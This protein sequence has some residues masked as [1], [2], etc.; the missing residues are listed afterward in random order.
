M[1]AHAR[2]PRD[3]FEGRDH[4]EIPAFQRPYV[5][6]E[7]DQW[8][9]L[10]DDVVR[11]AD[12]YVTG[13]LI[14]A[15]PKVPH[16]FLGAVVYESKPLITGDVARHEVIDG[17]QR[18]TTLQVLIDATH[19][20]LDEHGFDDLADTLDEL[21]RNRQNAFK[22]K[23]E[24]F[25]LWPS[26]TDRDA[27]VAVMEGSTGASDHPLRKAH[28]FFLGEVRRWVAG[29]PDE[30]DLVPPGTMELRVEALASTL[31]D[32]LLLVAID[33][34]GHD[35][36]Q[37]IFETL[38]DRGTPLLKADLIKNWVFRRAEQVGADTEAWASTYW[39]DFDGAWWREEITQGR[40]TRSRVDIFLQYWLTMRRSDEV[41]AEHVFRVFV[42]HAEPHML[43]AEAS[44]RLLTAL[45]HD[46]DTYKGFAQ[47]DATTPAGHYHRLVIETMELAAT[48]PV[49][50]WLLSENHGVPDTQAALGL[51]AIESWVIR[52]SLLR[53][54]TKDVNKFMVAV[55]KILDAAD[56]A[57]A[58]VRLREYLSEQTAD[59]RF[60]PSDDLLRSQVPTLRIYGALRQSRIRAIF[61]EVERHLRGQSAFYE[62]VTLPEGLEVEHIMP[63]GWRT[64]W[65]AEPPLDQQLASERDAA[66]HTLGNLTL[67][68]KSLNAS[69][70]NRPWTDAD[71]T[72][73]KEGGFTGQ[74]KHTLLSQFSLLA[75]NKQI[76]QH[77]EAWTEADIDERS[78]ELTG[79]LC[80]VWPGPNVAV[81]QAALEAQR[82]AHPAKKAELP[83]VPWTDDDMRRLAKEAGEAMTVVLDTLALHP[84]EG[85]SNARFIAEGITDRAFA[86]LGALTM[87]AKGPF[88]RSNS[89]VTYGKYGSEW[90]WSLS[91]ELAASWR[92]ARGLPLV[93]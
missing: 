72:G 37:L 71:A 52:R 8:A 70:S 93:D 48:T 55:L 64:H 38:N 83:E 9:P 12:S 19:D 2:S 90:R 61:A 35:D 87:K 33:L 5:W 62:A 86:A 7:E 54:T 34:T 59:T 91:P 57:E 27:F 30:D 29:E 24:R 43:D 28:E 74:G 47:L 44:E 53:L 67:T 69:L 82:P 79:V 75:I 46:A 20:V 1:E 63:R 39:A 17:Q 77:T 50:L 42:E 49:F 89:P 81:Q 14:D 45:R 76:L 26:Q 25:K 58:G 3:I 11:V 41:K 78:G 23:R 92:A 6:N 13:K 40:L 16:H 10:W 15:D 21:T 80:A 60:W 68:T 32:R 36:S 22:G 85:W 73:L 18:M 66:V 4:F 56:P 84:G 31:Q 65:D 88:G 51:A